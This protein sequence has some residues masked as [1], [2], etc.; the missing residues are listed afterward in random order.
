MSGVERRQRALDR[1]LRG[2]VDLG[3]EVLGGLADSRQ[4]LRPALAQDRDGLVH[5]GVRR[6]QFALHSRILAIAMYFQLQAGA[7]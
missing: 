1:G 5:R 6:C 2:Q 7:L 4:R 3:Q